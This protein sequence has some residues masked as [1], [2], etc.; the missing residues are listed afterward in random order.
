MVNQ[1]ALVRAR[2]GD[3]LAFA[4]LT[5][6][7]RRELLLHCYRMLGTIQDAE[8][9]LQETLVAAWRGLDRFEERAGL[10]TWLYRIATNRCLNALRARDRRP[11]MYTPEVPLPEPTRVVDPLWLEPFPDLLLSQLPDGAPGPEAVLEQRESL[12]LAFLVTVHS[13]PPR[14]RAVLLL[15][16]V[17]GYRT[18][19]VARM[20]ETSEDAVGSALKRARATLTTQPP[21]N[22]PAPGSPAEQAVVDEFADAFQDGD[23]PRVVA[24]LTDDA[25]LTMPPLPLEYQGP[26][27]VAEFLV[28]IPFRGARSYRLVPTRANTQPAFGAYLRDAHS[29]IWHAHGLVV[30]TLTGSEISAVTRF[31]DTG[32]LRHFGLPRTLRD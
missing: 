11:D 17:L 9:L 1:S 19:E 30:L 4:E 15:R 3:G 23:V 29:P 28:T 21:D 16:D 20:L 13:L 32:L 25:W 2:S 12:R 24:L 14:Q 10:R 18:A 22:A 26:E 27:R 6:P 7:F 31:M 8:D 5:Q